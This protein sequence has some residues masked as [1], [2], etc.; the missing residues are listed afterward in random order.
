VPERVVFDTNIL[1][2]GLL[3]RGKPYQ[4]LLLARSGIVQPVYCPPMA[5]F[6]A[7]FQD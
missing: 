4:C 5:E 6:L 2:S 7:R 1:I 3:W